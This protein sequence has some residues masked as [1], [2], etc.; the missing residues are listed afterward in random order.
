MTPS[1]VSA[2]KTSPAGKRSSKSIALMTRFFAANCLSG[3]NDRRCRPSIDARRSSDNDAPRLTAD[4]VAAR[5]ANI[6][7]PGRDAPARPG[8]HEDF[9][10]EAIAFARQ[11]AGQRRSIAFLDDDA[12]DALR[13]HRLEEFEGLIAIG[14]CRQQ[15]DPPRAVHR[16][17]GGVD[18]L[19]EGLDGDLRRIERANGCL[20]ARTQATNSARRKR[21]RLARITSEPVER[22]QPFKR[23][24]R[25]TPHRW[26]LRLRSDEN[27]RPPSLAKNE[28]N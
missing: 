10:H 8:L 15:I 22:I 21:I 1:G 24:Y 5:P 12:S 2:T 13:D 7:T 4:V 27:R 3:F 9:D 25:E 20:A 14:G 28:A 23:K 6:E 18:R 16:R 11:R 26:N 19:Q 17:D